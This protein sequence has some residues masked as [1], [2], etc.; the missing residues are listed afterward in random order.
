MLHMPP[1]GPL[2]PGSLLVLPHFLYTLA[3]FLAR[4]AFVLIITKKSHQ[5]AMKK[6]IHDVV[7]V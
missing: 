5:M 2:R 4:F 7:D 3:A 6:S 1:S